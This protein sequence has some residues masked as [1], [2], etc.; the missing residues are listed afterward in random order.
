MVTI[1]QKVKMFSKLVYQEVDSDLDRQKAAL[2]EKQN[3]RLEKA[4]QKAKE[5][6][7]EILNATEYKIRERENQAIGKAKIESKRDILKA[8][9]DCIEQMIMKLENKI[10]KF[11][12]TSDYE[13][14]IKSCIQ[15]STKVMEIGSPLK[16]VLNSEDAQRFKHMLE[17][18][19]F[20]IEIASPA[21]MGGIIIIDPKNSTQV[22]FSIDST[23][24]DMMPIITNEIMTKLGK[25]GDCIE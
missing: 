5:K 3:E 24:E 8:R 12:R 19:N 13:K 11:M 1:E 7:K 4:T 20:S 17:R 9:E 21:I 15:K 14:Y 23:L 2:K 25:V 6:A 22:D 16:A 18:Y 10:F